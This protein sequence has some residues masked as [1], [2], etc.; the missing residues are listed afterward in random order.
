MAPVLTAM[1]LDCTRR[2][3]RISCAQDVAAAAAPVALDPSL[4]SSDRSLPTL[5]RSAASELALCMSSDL[6]L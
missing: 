3:T 1:P 4:P 5:K 6:A 2:R